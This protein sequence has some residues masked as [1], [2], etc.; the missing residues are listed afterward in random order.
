M[1]SPPPT[2]TYSSSP[3][4][5]NRHLV[6]F[7]LVELLVV[8]GIIALLIGIILPVMSRARASAAATECASNLKQVA[9]AMQMYLNE[10]A[11]Y[12]FWHGKK[13][14]VDGMD[15]FCYGGQEKGNANP[16]PLFNNLI[17]RP[18]NRY[19]PQVKIF[20]CPRNNEPDFWTTGCSHFEW[21]GNSY[22]FNANGYPLTATLTGGLAG[23][24]VTSVRDASNTVMFF[25]AALYYDR[26]WHYSGKGNICFVDSHVEFMP[27][28]DDTGQ[29]RW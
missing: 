25:D 27:L 11:Q 16:I 28:P 18:L 7:T 4:A 12:I 19:A 17:P 20:R 13:L 23:V 22:H 6:G 1:L 14:E 9:T 29:Y 10:N 2:S 24:R 21:V 8:I 26:T 15:W 3:S 5:P